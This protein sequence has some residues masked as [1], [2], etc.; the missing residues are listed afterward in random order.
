MAMRVPRSRSWDR[1]T[2]ACSGSG[3]IPDSVTSKPITAGSTPVNS[4]IREIWATTATDPSWLGD[5]FTHT[6]TGRSRSSFHS[7]EA[8][9]ARVRT[10]S[11]TSGISPTSSATGMNRTGGSTP[12]AGAS[13]RAKASRP[14]T[15]PSSRRTVG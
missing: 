9:H 5:R 11:N 7:L 8:S 15:A 2:A 4:M 12:P 13:Q 6:T 3:K 1:N 14:S 10:V